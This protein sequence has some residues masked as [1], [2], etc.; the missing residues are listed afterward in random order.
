[1]ETSYIIQVVD[2]VKPLF[3]IGPEEAASGKSDAAQEPTPLGL[4]L[5]AVTD[6][7]SA[8]RFD[9]KGRAEHQ[10]K[11]YANDLPDLKFVVLE[12]LAPT[13]SF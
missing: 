8:Q 3:Y 9:N 10:A 11:Q 2:A 7:L 13:V 5:R 4:S 6:P 12:I 1:M